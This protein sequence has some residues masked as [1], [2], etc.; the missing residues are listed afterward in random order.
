MPDGYSEIFRYLSQC[1]SVVGLPW[2]KIELV[3][4]SS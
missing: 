3:F 2:H 1:N 4:A